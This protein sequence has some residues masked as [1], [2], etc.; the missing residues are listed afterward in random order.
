MSNSNPYFG[1]ICPAITPFN[2]QNKIDFG[3]MEQHYKMLTDSKINGI[4]VMGT[5]G[6]FVTMTIQERLEII[7]QAHQFTDLPLIVNVSTTVVDDMVKLADAAFDAG[8]GAVMAL[9]HFYFAQTPNQLYE[10]YKYLDSKFVGNWFIYNFPARTGC[11]VDSQLVT[12]LISDFPKFIGIK[13]TVDCASH[14]RSIVLAS[15]KIRK[16]FSVFSG[17]DEYFVPNLMNGGA[18][19]LSGLNNV[20]PEIFASVMAAFKQND[21]NELTRLHKEISQLSN[22]Y[23]IGDDFVTTIKVA[24]EQKQHYLEPRSRNFGGTLSGEQIEKIKKLF[25]CQ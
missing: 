19:V 24:V 9:P 5:I 11:D 12:R 21:F 23:S 8:Y 6:E 25:N 2:R 22:I 15:Q 14:T 20:V 4:L 1:A 18:G 3:A 10:Y 13:D 7:K 16:D 17:F